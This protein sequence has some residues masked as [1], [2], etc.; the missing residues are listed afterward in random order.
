MTSVEN[1][2][3]VR[4]IWISDTHL[5]S[6]GCKAD[7]LIEFLKVHR[8]ETLY[9]V[10]DIIDGWR[11]KRSIYWPQSHSNV[12]RRILTLAKRGTKVVYITGNHDEFLRKYAEHD[13]GNIHLVNEALHETRTGKRFLVLHGDKFDV[14]VR[15]HKWIAVLGDIA[16]NLLLVLNRWYNRIRIGLGY[17]YW[18]LSNFLKHRVK[19]AVNFIGDYELALADECKKR[20]LDG[21]ICGHI[22][23]AEIRTIDG[24]EYHNCGD[25]VESCTALVETR[26]GSIELVNWIDELESVNLLHAVAS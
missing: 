11:M 24:V 8:C 16:Y 22:H 9:L 23:H 15:Y 3:R 12:I 1:K 26:S 19:Q 20:G 25:W 4:A 6:K 14:I 17:G 5:G 10:G 21:V 13:F 7:Y 2:R 18:S